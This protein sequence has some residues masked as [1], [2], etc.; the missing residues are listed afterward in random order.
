MFVS[1][2]SLKMAGT[3]S[4]VVGLMLL[5]VQLCA[6]EQHAVQQAGDSVGL[7]QAGDLRSLQQVGRLRD[8]HCPEASVILP[9]VCTVDA[10]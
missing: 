7:Q 6:A 9:C 4:C 8:L 2:G 10:N 1:R 3:V 5:L